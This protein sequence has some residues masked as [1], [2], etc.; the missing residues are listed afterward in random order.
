MLQQDSQ[1]IALAS[2]V[3][4][5]SKVSANR[6]A[7]S[8][9]DSCP[10]LSSEDC[11]QESMGRIMFQLTLDQLFGSEQQAIFEGKTWVSTLESIVNHA[12][13]TVQD[14]L[15]STSLRMQHL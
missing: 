7:F 15:C 11:L 9:F 5:V 13:F 2:R 6:S 3:L 12:V 4:K 10:F 8:L 14:V 1:Y